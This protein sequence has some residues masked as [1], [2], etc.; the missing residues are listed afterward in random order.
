M[1]I[2]LSMLLLDA[3]RMITKIVVFQ[4]LRSNCT[5]I[6]GTLQNFMITV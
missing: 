2:S 5:M 6:L 1:T 4:G 3:S